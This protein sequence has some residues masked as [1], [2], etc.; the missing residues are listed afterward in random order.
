M[1]SSAEVSSISSVI[2][3]AVLHCPKWWLHKFVKYYV[4]RGVD[5]RITGKCIA[6]EALSSRFKPVVLIAML[7]HKNDM[8]HILYHSRRSQTNDKDV[9]DFADLET[10]P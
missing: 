1:V 10:I 6:T 2:P 5:R 4:G 3:Q 8:F 7:N 9:F